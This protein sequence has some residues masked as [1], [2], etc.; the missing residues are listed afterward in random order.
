MSYKEEKA[1]LEDKI[2]PLECVNEIIE[3]LES[4]YCEDEGKR[5]PKELYKYGGT[6]SVAHSEALLLKKKLTQMED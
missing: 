3:C 5:L 1:K 4:L 6:I 2:T